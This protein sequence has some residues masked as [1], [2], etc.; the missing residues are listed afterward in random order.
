M[1][2]YLKSCLMNKT[3]IDN[4]LILV[5]KVVN[6]T[7]G[8]LEQAIEYDSFGNIL[9]D[10]NPNFQPFRLAGGL[11]DND[12]KLTRFGAR[13]YDARDGRWTAKDPIKFGGGIN[14]YVYVGNEPIKRTDI[15][16]LAYR[17]TRPLGI[18]KGVQMGVAYYE[19]LC[20][21]DGVCAGLTT[22]DGLMLVG[23]TVVGR[24][25]TPIEDSLD[26]GICR[27]ITDNQCMVN[28]LKTMFDAFLGSDYNL[29]SYNC[30]DWAYDVYDYC[31]AMC[32][33]YDMS[34]YYPNDEVTYE[35]Y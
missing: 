34:N 1:N 13:D 25:T 32:G 31:T 11:Y 3:I 4:Q 10:S 18:A 5:I 7:N 20:T 35:S 16:G 21:E 6:T 23:V 24:L 17:C 27:E 19:Y 29:Y 14:F 30:K 28:C 33:V 22:D 15:L 9:S 12:T 26:T 2:I 8:T